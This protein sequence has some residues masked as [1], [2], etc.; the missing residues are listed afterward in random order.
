MNAVVFGF[1]A[2]GEHAVG[3]GHGGHHGHLL[4]AAFAASMQDLAR[5]VVSARFAYTLEDTMTAGMRL[6]G[7]N[8]DSETTEPTSIGKP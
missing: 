5:T 1:D 6:L 8:S 2:S 3:Q 4:A 7:F